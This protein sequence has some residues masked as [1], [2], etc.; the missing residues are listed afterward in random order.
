MLPDEEVTFTVTAAG[1]ES[2]SETVKFA[3]G[4]NKEV[5]IKLK[6][7]SGAV[8]A[9]NSAVDGAVKLLEKVKPDASADK[10]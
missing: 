6:A 1:Y 8:D 7:V 10:D 4:D 9:I 2:A 3:E 5:M